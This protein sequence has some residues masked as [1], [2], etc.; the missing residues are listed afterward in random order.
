V[1]RI[2]FLSASVGVGHTAA[3]RAL[4]AA[5]AVR[6]D[7]YRC[8]IVDSYRYAASYFSK[9]VAD[10]YIGMVRTMPQL[11]R[12]I[13][14][15]AERASK[16]S[17]FR[18]WVSDFTAANLRELVAELRPSAV[19]CTH[20]FP[21]GVM[22]AYKQ[23]FDAALPV[24]GIVTD[25][26]VHPF[27]IYRNVDAYAVATPE[28]RSA[29]LARGVEGNRIVVCGIPVDERFARSRHERRALRERLGLPPDRAQVLMM[30]GGLG[31]GPLEMMM[32]ALRQVEMPLAATV[33]V[34]RNRRLEERVLAR[35]RQVDYPVRV[36]GFVDNVYDYMHAS[37]VLVTKPGGLSTSEALVAQLPMVLVKPLPGQ[38]ERNARYLLGK[39]A[40]IRATGE[41]QIARAVEAL[42]ASEERRTSLLAQAAEVS[43]P[44]AAALAAE[45][46]IEL[47]EYS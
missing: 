5:I 6:T 43:R 45:R 22:A 46:I 40:A 33:I 38:E 36:V 16:I 39:R 26:V 20:A 31:M 9:V 34:G 47:S 3:A 1:R 18:R 25:F 12:Y 30:A 21:C 29:L 8:E 10:G 37:D 15:R 44:D 17:G 4:A 32:E 23:Q 28:M 27:W 7:D 24:I 42:L 35:A 19:V 2:L 41:R 14:D 13:Y 11:Y